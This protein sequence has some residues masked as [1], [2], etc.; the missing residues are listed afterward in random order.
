MNFDAKKR[1]R[2]QDWNGEL[3]E[4][5]MFYFLSRRLVEKELFQN[6]NCDVVVVDDK[7]SLEIDNI[8]DLKLAELMLSL[9]SQITA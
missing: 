2:R 1:P 9:D 3:I 6:E 8:Y 5:G 7:D 4:N